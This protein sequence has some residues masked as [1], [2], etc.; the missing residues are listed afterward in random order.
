M[1]MP[2]A[3][4]KDL[5]ST[6][7][8][9]DELKN[10]SQSP[11]IDV[12]TY[13]IDLTVPFLT[14]ISESYDKAGQPS[15]SGILR[16]AIEYLSNPSDDEIVD[17]IL[18]LKKVVE[19]EIGKIDKA[20]VQEQLDKSKSLANRQRLES[21][22]FVLKLLVNI[23]KTFRLTNPNANK[24]KADTVENPVFEAIIQSWEALENMA[25]KAAFLP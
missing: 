3:L 1:E 16:L 6:G 25:P 5:R 2:H 15:R 21:A 11:E 4:V 7:Y 20:A 8:F 22:A 18:G 10:F 14:K 9:F 12:K 23:I 24:R 17:C 13:C 19:S